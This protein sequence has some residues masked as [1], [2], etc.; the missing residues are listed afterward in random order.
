[1]VSMSERAARFNGYHAST[2]CCVRLSRSEASASPHPLRD[3]TTEANAARGALQALL[4]TLPLTKEQRRK[5]YGAAASWALAEGR[6][7]TWQILV[8]QAES[9][10]RERHERRQPEG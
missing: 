6:R 5:V 10:A 2:K 7:S 8:R 3:H 1:M 9:R 4:K